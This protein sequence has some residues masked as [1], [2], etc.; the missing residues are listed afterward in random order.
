M[1]KSERVTISESSLINGICR[2]N[3]L[4][5]HREKKYEEKNTFRKKINDL[6]KKA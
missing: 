1:I 5:F 2:A 6:K 3:S 4:H